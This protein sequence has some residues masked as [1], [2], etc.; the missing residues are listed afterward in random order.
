MSDY[1]KDLF[2]NNIDTDAIS[3]HYDVEAVSVKLLFHG[4]F[5][6]PFGMKLSGFIDM[7]DRKGTG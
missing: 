7:K 2:F 6:D 1:D 4:H 5:F 3:F